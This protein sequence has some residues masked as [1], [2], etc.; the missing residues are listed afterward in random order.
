MARP[1]RHLPGEQ[2]WIV[3]WLDAIR[4]RRALASEAFRATLA[5]LTGLHVVVEPINTDAERDGLLSADLQADVESVLR[6]GGLAVH[7]QSALF[8]GVPGTPVFHVDIMTIRLDGRYAYS[9]RLELWQGVKLARD[10]GRTALALTWSAPQVVGT[11][12]AVNLDT[13]RDVV[14]TAV[15]GFV[16]ECRLASAD[17]A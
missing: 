3:A 16:E 8:A 14:R 4:R 7:A 17:Q 15:R 13:L 10:P 1:V 12:A 2:P 6:E 11:L 9:I 5:G